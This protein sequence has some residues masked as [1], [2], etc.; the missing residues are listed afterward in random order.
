MLANDS[1]AS[2][3]GPS[4]RDGSQLRLRVVVCSH[5][6]LLR[7][8]ISLA[9]AQ[10]ELIDVCGTVDPAASRT[11]VESLSPDVLLLDA[12]VD[13]GRKLPSI[14]REVMPKLRIVV[15]AVA[16]EQLDVVGW[17]EAGVSGHVGRDGGVAELTA[18]IH[19]AVR[20]EVFCSPKLAALLFARIAELSH[21]STVSPPSSGLTPRE[22]EILLLVD[23]GL[24]NKEIARRLGIEHA[25]VKNH[26]HHILEKMNARG[27]GEAAA[28]IRQS[29]AQTTLA[30]A[31]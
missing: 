11:K 27:R 6:R 7:E 14:L 26:I 13:A 28:R 12:S 29:T 21:E 5:I 19:A 24:P 31:P 30:P 1:S 15:F 9:L 22:H 2:A 8:G 17:A 20:G 3:D 23:Q 4:R 16:D 18:A 25:T 10:D